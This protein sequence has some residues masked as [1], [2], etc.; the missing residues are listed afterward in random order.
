MANPFKLPLAGVALR[1]LVSRPAT[2]RYPL[3]VRPPVALARGHVAVDMASCVFCGLCARR[4]PAAAIVVSKEARTFALEH[5]RCVSCGVC[6]D[7]CNKDSLAMAPAAQ[8]VYLAHE[9][10]PQGTARRGLEHHH[11][12]PEPKPAPKPEPA[13]EKPAPAAGG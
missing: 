8:H 10:G 5:L 7:V 2:R 3:E 12:P 1:N 9:A 4:C 11:K 13:A 6:V